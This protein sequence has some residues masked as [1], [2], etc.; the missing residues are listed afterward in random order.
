MARL[1]KDIYQ[2]AKIAHKQGDLENAMKLY[3]ESTYF[4]NAAKVAL[5]YT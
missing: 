3:A 1:P 4:H 5:Q 2:D